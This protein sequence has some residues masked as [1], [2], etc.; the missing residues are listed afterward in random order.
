MKSNG[1]GIVLNM[2]LLLFTTASIQAQESLTLDSKPT[3]TISGTSSL[4]DWDMT[5]GTA[6]G[7]LVA[8]LE[9]T[10]LDKIISL[11]VEMPAETIKSGKS[12]MD[13]NAY[14]ALKTSQYKTVK[15]DLKQAQKTGTGYTLKGTFTIAGVAKEVSIPI[16]VTSAGGKH[17]LTGD[18]S[19]KLTDYKITPP[20]AMLG[21]IK[22]GDAVKIA[23]TVS[24][25]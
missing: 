19:F 20:T 4:H 21:T 15:F 23:F 12:G 2:I 3:L 5:S 17:T 18:Y 7:K 6:T 13:K 14:K 10:K 11:I 8:T 22:T 24:F 9:G 25:K 16:K 1:I